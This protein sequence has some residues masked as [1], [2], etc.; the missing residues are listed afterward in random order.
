MPNRPIRHAMIPIVSGPAI[1]LPPTVRPITEA[2]RR[3]HDA[4]RTRIAEIYADPGSVARNYPVIS[5]ALRRHSTAEERTLYDSL[6]DVGVALREQG[7][8]ELSLQLLAQ[9]RTSRQQHQALASMLRRLDGL[10]FDDPQWRPRFDEAVRALDTHLATEETVVFAEARSVFPMPIQIEL[11]SR[12]EAIMHE[13]G[14]RPVR[15][16]T[17]IANPTPRRDIERLLVHTP[18]LDAIFGK[19]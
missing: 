3:D 19:R 16:G 18:I 17:R 13:S 2:L 12:Y 5:E 11:G 1:A 7:Q 10:R 15:T 14:R 6:R 9:I 4:V 8:P